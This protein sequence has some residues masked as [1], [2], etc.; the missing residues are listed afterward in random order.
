M[1]EL[2]YQCSVKAG[3]V[4]HRTRVPLR[5]WLWA[6]FFLAR[7][8]KDVSGAAAPAR[9]RARQLRDGLD[10]GPQASFGP[11]APCGHRLAGGR[12]DLRGRAGARPTRRPGGPLQDHRGRRPSSS[13]YTAQAG[14]G[15]PSS[16]DWIAGRVRWSA[17]GE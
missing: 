16:R 5:T 9:H 17:D 12:R 11:A 15:W 8:K 7:H 10:D 4:F 14:C 6:I 2:P 13:A 1:P 3:T